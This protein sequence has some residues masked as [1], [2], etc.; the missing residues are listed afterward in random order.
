MPHKPTS[1]HCFYLYIISY[2]NIVFTHKTL[3]LSIYYPTNIG[4]AEGFN[5]FM[6]ERR[7]IPRVQEENNDLKRVNGPI[8]P[9]WLFVG[10]TLINILHLLTKELFFTLI[11][12]QVILLKKMFI[13]KLSTK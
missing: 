13:F 12:H 10:K 7:N 3:F 4:K 11:N 2:K 5:I 8:C 9:M 6:G 1:S